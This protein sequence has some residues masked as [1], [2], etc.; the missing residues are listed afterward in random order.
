MARPRRGAG[1]TS[2]SDDNRLQVLRK[3]LDVLAERVESVLESEEWIQAKLREMSL[4]LAALAPSEPDGAAD[5]KEVSSEA[6]PSYLKSIRMIRETVRRVLPR[7]ATVAIVSKGDERLMDLYGRPAWHF[8]QDSTGRYP[9]YYP[10]DGTSVIAQL[11]SLRIRGAAYL[12]FPKSAFWW[13]ERYPIFSGHLLSHYRVVHR[14]EDSCVIFALEE[15]RANGG[16]DS[17]K[18]RLPELITEF[19]ECNDSGPSILD[20]N[21]GLGLAD[22]FT[23][24]AVVAPPGN[25]RR[26]PYLD[27]SFDIVVVP[28]RAKATMGE[29][30][31]VARYAVVAL[32]RDRKADP[33]GAGVTVER[34]GAPAADAH[35]PTTSIIIPTYNGVD[36]LRV[37]LAT[38]KDAL[39]ERFEGEVIVV[40]DGSGEEMRRSLAEW[41]GEYPFLKVIRNARNRGFVASCNRG[42]RAAKGKVL[43]FLNDDTMPQVGWLQALHRTLRRY[44]D[45]GA[46]GG[47]LIYP[48]GRLQEAGNLVFDDGSAANFGRDDS[49][50]ENPLYN[51]LREVDYCSAAVLATPRDLFNEI[52][53]FDKRFEPGYYEDTDYCFAVRRQGRR[54]YYQPECIVVHTEGATGGTDLTSGAKRY[55]VVNQA[56]FARKWKTALKAQPKRPAVIDKAALYRLSARGAQR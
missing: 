28:S 20:W 10:T 38:L 35:A 42:A 15:S 56:K 18:V 40:D 39:P 46:V 45:A 44:P 53:G 50:A 14:D 8:P 21:T 5:T 36:Q 19:A 43:V 32:R 1:K 11:E 26:L 16:A 48:D 2:T 31:R 25:G 51:Y 34:V 7:D 3:D 54:V 47:K 33:D 55:Q 29:A 12:L 37:C 30:R 23:S 52:G 6:N 9:G 49:M 4:A 17:W 41:G 13:L 22:R 27:G 24:D